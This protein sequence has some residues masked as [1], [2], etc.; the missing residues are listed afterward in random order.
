MWPYF[1]LIASE[2]DWEVHQTTGVPPQQGKTSMIPVRHDYLVITFMWVNVM[3]NKR[4]WNLMEMSQ[5]CVHEWAQLDWFYKEF[6]YSHYPSM[7]PDIF[8][9]LWDSVLVRVYLCFPIF[10]SFHYFWDSFLWLCYFK[11]DVSAIQVAE[12]VNH[13]HKGGSTRH[14]S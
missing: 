10:L 1:S 11:T 4:C 12:T 9:L 2:D 5:S 7:S 3:E 14:S 8:I 13:S 6:L